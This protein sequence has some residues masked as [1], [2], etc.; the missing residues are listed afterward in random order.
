MSARKYPPLAERLWAGALADGTGCWVWRRGLNDSGYGWIKSGGRTRRAHR[1]AYE[2]V[3]GPI[4][5][6]LEIDHLCRVRACINPD[7]LEAVTHRE[8]QLRGK[9]VG[10]ANARKTHC[11]RGHPY[12]ATNTY[13]PPSGGRHCRGCLNRRARQKRATARRTGTVGG[14]R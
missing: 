11:L 14:R 9:T 1:V 12:D 2:L 13:R 3:K 8:N 4:P 5:D 7:H 10:A 6:G